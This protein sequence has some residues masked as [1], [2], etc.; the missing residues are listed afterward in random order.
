MNTSAH[1]LVLAAAVVFNASAASTIRF[2]FATDAVDENTPE[3]VIEVWRTG[4]VTT[5]ATA[6]FRTADV[7]AKAGEDYGATTGR[8][9]LEPGSTHTTIR[10][11]LLND[12]LN[13]PTETVLVQLANPSADTTVGGATTVTLRGNDGI[14]LEFTAYSGGE[15]TGSVTLALVRGPDE[16]APASVDYVS[17][18][19]TATAGADY[20]AASGTALFPTGERVSL[21]EMPIL[22]DG[23]NESDETFRVNFSNASGGTL[24][25]PTSATVTILDDDKGV[26]FVQ[27]RLRVHEDQDGVRVEVARGNDGLLDP[28]VVD[29]TVTNG[30]AMAGEDFTLPSGSLSF[31]AGEMTRSLWVPAINDSVAEADQTFRVTLSNPTAGLALGQTANRTATVTIC[32]ATGME[33]RRFRGIQRL[34]DG[35]IQLELQG[36]VH[37][38]FLP[39][40]SVFQL[41]SSSDLRQWA[42]LKLL[43]HRNNSANPPVLT[44]VPAPGATTRFYRVSTTPFVTPSIPPTGPHPVGIVRRFLFD[45]SRRNRFGIST[46][47]SFFATIW[48]PASPGSSQTIAGYYPVTHAGEAD[49]IVSQIGSG[50]FNRAEFMD[51]APRLVSFSVLDAPLRSRA[52]GYPT[53]VKSHGYQY[54]GGDQENLAEN[55][56]SHGYIVAAIDHEDAPFSLLPD[57]SLVRYTPPPGGTVA[58]ILERVKDLRFFVGELTKLNK[59]HPILLG[60]FQFS[61][62]AGLGWSYGAATVAEF[63]RQ[64]S[65]CL[66]AVALDGLGGILALYEMNRI[67]LQ[68][69]SLTMNNPNNSIDVLFK[70]AARDAYWLQISGANHYDFST[71]WWDDSSIELGREIQQTIHAYVLSFP[72]KHVKAEDHHLLDAKAPAF[73]RVSTFRKKLCLEEREQNVLET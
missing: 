57:G 1:S 26:E 2:Q 45:P 72:D 3:A 64:D 40:C 54:D 44:D 49:Y 5:T 25:N 34:A 71:V 30:T 59:D 21:I 50:D 17:A 19:G 43:G 41:E 60:G 48:Y 69:P 58:G 70:L 56:A 20:A 67:G 4:D 37:K 23:L 24:L 47:N 10:I 28:F 39:Y 18:P 38:R 13:E 63:A 15:G 73:P 31:A 32:D 42:P 9:S 7:A 62:L 6:D 33:P 51:R 14:K 11:P 22:K 46:N 66:A 35:A 29:Y 27:N 52:G 68:K 55:L 16:T 36:G 65:K 12:A 8:L 53:I 61:R